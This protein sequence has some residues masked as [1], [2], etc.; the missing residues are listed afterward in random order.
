M[1]TLPID[2]QHILVPIV[3]FL[4]GFGVIY[5]FLNTRYRER[6]AMIEKGIDPRSAFEGSA[7]HRALRYG[8]L[9]AGGGL[10]MLTGS[11]LESIFPK[12]D[13]LMPGSV[14]LFGGLGL[15]TYYLIVGKKE[16]A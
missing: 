14:L 8:L 16:K 7:K 3:L 12:V 15:L 1:Q 11:S 6:L 2:L 10:G 9:A 5:I 4:T 13:M